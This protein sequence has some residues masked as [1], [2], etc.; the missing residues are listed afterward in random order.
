MV[1]ELVKK[2]EHEA[3]AYAVMPFV[4]SIGTII[5]PAIGGTLADPSETFPHMFSKHGL[6]A[7]FP[8]LLPNLIC[9]ALLLVSIVLGYFFLA[10]THPDLQP[11]STEQDLETSTAE[12]PL[13]VDAGATADRAV[14]LKTDAYGT[15]NQVDLRQ[16]EHWIIDA[17]AS[18][19]PHSLSDKTRATF[20]TWPVSM[21][22]AALGIFTYHSMTFDHLLPI[23]L[24]DDRN[25][26]F[27]I[28]TNSMLNIPGG[29][30]LTTQTVGIIMSFDGLI[31][32]FIQGV[33]FPFAANRLGV[34]RVF[35]LVTMLQ[36][37]VYFI[38]PYLAM[39]P[40]NLLFPGIYACLTIRNLLSI[41]AYPAMLILLR[42]AS[43]SPSML[44]KINGLAAS[45]GAACRTVGPPVAGL[46]YGLGTKIG[47]TG[48]AWWGSVLV[49]LIGV[50]QMWF[51]RR[52]NHA[53]IV[54]DAP[55]SMARY[56]DLEPKKSEGILV[57]IVEC[58]SD[59][60]V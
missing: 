13:L 24:Q 15:F 55:P 37:I 23:F 50:F 42:Q 43:P 22:V 48:L 51:V 33:V 21:L 57:T 18:S 58:E 35:I 16:D 10:E 47:F 6:F 11:W 28:M 59:E 12:T 46:L 5:G 38:V 30:G 7:T 25:D 34:W 60:E 45:V 19:R 20:M 3:R 39:L 8:Y 40:E 4:W 32:L 44:G 2:P 41:L 52:E 9:G 31:A 14:N 26:D 56:V 36:P 53:S 29:L 54:Q 1:G 27:T 49:A 17:G